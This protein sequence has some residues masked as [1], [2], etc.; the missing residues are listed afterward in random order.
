MWREA[1][2]L[3]QGTYKARVHVGATWRKARICA[4]S[5][6]G[7]QAPVPQHTEIA[8][9]LGELLCELIRKQLGLRQ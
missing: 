1:T 9:S 3:R 7:R 8:D 6:N 2:G 5:G 4:N